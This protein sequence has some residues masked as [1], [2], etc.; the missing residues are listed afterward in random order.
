MDVHPISELVNVQ[1]AGLQMESVETSSSRKSAVP[2]ACNQRGA[3]IRRRKSKQTSATPEASIGGRIPDLACVKQEPETDATK[4]L[5]KRRRRSGVDMVMEVESSLPSNPHSSTRPRHLV[6]RRYSPSPEVRVGSRLRSIIASVPVNRGKIERNKTEFPL[7]K[8]PSDCEITSNVICDRLRC[9]VE[10]FSLN[11]PKRSTN[12]KNAIKSDNIGVI[13]L[14][15]NECSFA[16]A[17]EQPIS[18]SS[19][20][21]DEENEQD[22]VP[23]VRMADIGAAPFSAAVLAGPP[24][25]L[26][27]KATRRRTPVPVIKLPNRR[28]FDLGKRR[29]SREMHVLPSSSQTP[30]QQRKPSVSAVTETCLTKD[31]ESVSF[32]TVYVMPVKTENFTLTVA[33]P[34]CR[35]KHMRGISTKEKNVTSPCPLGSRPRRVSAEKTLEFLAEVTR[36]KHSTSRDAAAGTAAFLTSRSP[37]TTSDVSLSHN[38]N[39]EA[40]IL[41]SPSARISAVIES[42]VKDKRTLRKESHPVSRSETADSPPSSPGSTRNSPSD[43]DWSA[44]AS[45]EGEIIRCE[46]G[47]QMRETRGSSFR[48]RNGRGRGGS[49]AVKTRGARSKR[50]VVDGNGE[51]SSST[52]RAS[53][54]VL[55]VRRSGRTHTPSS[56]LTDNEQSAKPSRSWS[57]AKHVNPNSALGILRRVSRSP[58]PQLTRHLVRAAEEKEKSLGVSPEAPAPSKEETKDVEELENKKGEE[59]AADPKLL[60]EKA[61]DSTPD[62]ETSDHPIVSSET[63][64]SDVPECSASTSDLETVQT[65]VEVQHEPDQKEVENVEQRKAA[66]RDVVDPAPVAQVGRLSSRTVRPSSRFVNSDFVSPLRKKRR[67]TDDSKKAVPKKEGDPTNTD[68]PEQGLESTA[69]ALKAE[70][71]SEAAA[72]SNTTANATAKKQPVPFKRSHVMKTRRGAREKPTIRL[73]IVFGR[74]PSVR[75]VEANSSGKAEPTVPS[76]VSSLPQPLKRK[77]PAKRYISPW[78]QYVPSVKPVLGNIYYSDGTVEKLGVSVNAVMDRLLAEV[79][80]DGI[81]RHSTI[82]NK[83]E[84]K[85]RNMEK[86]RERVHRLKEERE[87]RAAQGIPTMTATSQS[88][89][90]QQQQELGP[91][92]R[93]G[94]HRLLQKDFLYPSLKREMKAEKKKNEEIRRQRSRNVMNQLADSTR[95]TNSPVTSRRTVPLREPSPYDPEKEA[96]LLQEAEEREKKK[97]LTMPISFNTFLSSKTSALI[98]QPLLQ[99]QRCNDRNAAPDNFFREL[100]LPHRGANEPLEETWNEFD[101]DADDGLDVTTIDAVHIPKLD[102]YVAPP[103]PDESAEPVAAAVEKM[104]MRPPIYC[105]EDGISFLYERALEQPELR[106]NLLSMAIDCISALHVARLSA[107]GREAAVIIYNAVTHQAVKMRDVICM[108]S[109]EREEAVFWMHRYL[110]EMLPVELLATYLFLLRHT[111]LLNCQVKS[112]IRSTQNDTSPWPE[113][114]SIIG[115]YV[116]V[117]VVEPD[118]AELDR[119][120]VPGSLSDVVFVLVAPN[121]S[122]GDFSVR[123]R[124]HD[125]IFKWLREIGNPASVVVRLK[126]DDS[127]S[128]AL[129]EVFFTA[130]NIISRAVT[131]L[132]REYKQKRIVLVGWGTTC[133]LNHVVLNTVPGV[134]SI[135]D[136]AFPVLTLEGSR[137]EPEDDILL[138]YCPTLFV[139]GAEA[140]DYNAK[141][142]K[143]MRASMIMPTGL[144]VIGHA[145]SNLLVSCPTLSRLRVTQKV[146]N[147]CVVEQ[148]CDFLAMDWTKRERSRLVPM[149]LNDVFKVDLMQLKVDEKAAHASRRAKDDPGDNRARKKKSDVVLPS[150]AVREASP[151]PHP[152]SQLDSVRSNFQNVLKKA[153]SEKSLTWPEERQQPPSTFKEPRLPP[154]PGSSLASPVSGS[155]ESPNLLDPASISLT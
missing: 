16:V 11:K 129:S 61:I 149:P 99:P 125:T 130:V 70:Q 87:A 155:T 48:G 120:I 140:C 15:K 123:E 74:S 105:Q 106:R 32:E 18:Y 2:S 19:D 151:S 153:G 62:L 5:R 65:A 37:S 82:I 29:G 35:S 121:I 25:S 23:V 3:V 68:V 69:N 111:R 8:L 112:I 24:P 27:S 135:I 137:G 94:R 92:I 124:Y 76:E 139:V 116:E 9:N 12:I 75:L 58:S 46:E 136:L 117:S 72:S 104:L 142:M 122:V 113:I 54:T 21:D 42:V 144:V 85:K 53:P 59:T 63:H 56:K 50:T 55:N 44:S 30:K 134:S 51:L 83:R 96:K 80:Q 145:N 31:P 89:Q 4:N 131:K 100:L 52:S 138:T 17:N 57:P 143:M 84:K 71:A 91:R 146:V 34:S 154:K 78:S 64:K 101:V 13:A 67:T 133:C 66:G 103:E 22:S 95:E 81:T 26:T 115:K 132:V 38:V 47:V 147:R 41:S 77:S 97:R 119:T 14:P 36:R 88:S 118:A 90:S 102:D 108:F 107:C 45:A 10:E 98:A 73:K 1:A 43:S 60:E 79:C 93:S 20:D 40:E 150:P 6:T 49:S 33:Q 141:A 39:D 128:T 114:T 109:R 110:V 127:F 7:S 148:I 152:V 86:A 28:S 126:L